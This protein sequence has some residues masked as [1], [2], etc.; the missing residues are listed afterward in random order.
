MKAHRLRLLCTLLIITTTL[1]VVPLGARYARQDP[2]DWPGV[3][4]RIIFDENGDYVSG[5]SDGDGWHHYS[6]TSGVYRMWF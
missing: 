2:D 1:P 6:A 5:D 4:Y 3:W